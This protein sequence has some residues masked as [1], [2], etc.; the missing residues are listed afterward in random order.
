M[1]HLKI[2]KIIDG[3]NSISWAWYSFITNDSW[4]FFNAINSGWLDME[5]THRYGENPTEQDYWE[6]ISLNPQ[7]I[8]LSEKDFDSLVDKI[9]N[10]GGYD[11]KIAKVLNK[12]TLWD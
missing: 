3:F 8:Y 9:E 4:D 11:E 10:S 12:T 7:K 5:F 6:W 1:K 2:K